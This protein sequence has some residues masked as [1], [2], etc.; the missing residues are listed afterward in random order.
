MVKDELKKRKGIDLDVL[1]DFGPRV[2]NGY[3]VEGSSKVL[4]GRDPFL[5]DSDILRFLYGRKFVINDIIDDLYYHL[6]WRQTNSPQPMLTDDTLRLLNSGLLYMHG[7]TMDMCPILVLDF[8]KLAEL[9]RKK[10]IN[11]G[12][13]CS[14]H[15]F[16][17]NYIVNNMMV[18]GQAEKWVV[19]TNINQ[20]SLKD[21]PLG[22]FKACA[23]ELGTN[24]MDSASRQVVVNMTWI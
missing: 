13:F 23:R 8:I 2:P 18:P 16:Y 10:I 19:I 1:K 3:V 11:H 6:E 24:Y 22:M 15:N 20:F 5:R 21:M 9:L 14:L 12:N 7:R 17:G 4:N